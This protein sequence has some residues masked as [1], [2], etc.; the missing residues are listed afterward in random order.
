MT[1]V[2]DRFRHGYSVVFEAYLD[3]STEEALHAAYELGR[4]AV[5]RGLSMLDLA[6][7]HHSVF[8]A[9]LARAGVRDSTAV[10]D[11][12]ADLLLQ[13]LSAYEMVQRGF[14]EAQVTAALEKRH[15]AQLRQLADAFVAVNSRLSVRDVL[16]V[17]TERAVEIVGAHCCI[18]GL[19][20]EEEA[21]RLD[22]IAY[23]HP[24]GE[25]RFQLQ[26]DQLTRLTSFASGIDHT[27]RLSAVDVTGARW[28]GLATVFEDVSDLLVVPVPDQ[29]D[30]CMGFVLLMKLEGWFSE[31]DESIVIQLVEMLSASIDNVRLYEHEH[32]VAETLQRALLPSELPQPG[33]I[34]VAARYVPGAV[35]VNVGGDWFDVV[36]LPNDRTGIAVGDVMGRGVRAAS[37]M[38][39]MRTAF[40]AYALDGSEPESVVKRLNELIPSLDRDH[41]STLV[42]L[43]WDPLHRVARIVRAGHP[44]PLLIDADGK[45]RYLDDAVSM[46]LGVYAD[47][48]YGHADVE[49]SPRSTLLLYTDGLVEHKERLDDGFM[50]LQRAVACE[51]PNLEALCERVLE[52]MLPA[53]ATDDTALLALQ[54]Q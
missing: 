30:Q 17:V 19:S 20:G 40:R 44:P 37:I 45:T 36:C 23:A 47:E 18:A 53:D 48:Q 24:H 1:T 15:A 12:A 21:T 39:Q 5:R 43:V 2:P 50:R 34:S 28:P 38:G 35:G 33:G 46:P 13:T 10:V 42:Y 51:A 25:S 52:Q 32:R 7:L 6:S 49:I 31:K 26:I 3:E 41:F 16:E 29:R 22:A 9:T 54:F 14:R 11:A 4:E 27:T 8:G